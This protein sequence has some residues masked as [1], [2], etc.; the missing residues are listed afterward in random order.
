MPHMK[1]HRTF[2]LATNKGHAIGFEKDKPVHVPQHIVK[3]AVAI[4]A[5][6]VDEEE[7]VDVVP[8]PAP[9]PADPTSDIREAVFY[10]AFERIVASNN[11][12]DFGANAMPTIKAT[13]RETKFQNLDGKDVRAAWAHYRETKAG[14]N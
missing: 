9:P 14:A 12:R 11:S 13:E 8:A 5:V 6:F 1:L 2:V 4:G 7:K 3:D 10:A